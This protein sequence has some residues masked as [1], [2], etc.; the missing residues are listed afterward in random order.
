MRFETQE[1]L[2]SL[3][4]EHGGLIR[5][6][7]YAN[8]LGFSTPEKVEKGGLLFI[9]NDTVYFEDF[10]RQPGLLDLVGLKNKLV[11]QKFRKSCKKKE[12]SPH[13]PVRTGSAKSVIRGS[14]SSTQL[15][16][17]GIIV[18]S[19]VKTCYMITLSTGLSWFLE[20]LDENEFHEYLKGASHESVQSI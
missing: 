9:I 10:E 15:K 20:I 7:T 17:T 11:Y 14:R 6:K 13:F 18:K 5:F 12:I 1:F 16:K 3:E 8:F 2:E 19:F 4:K